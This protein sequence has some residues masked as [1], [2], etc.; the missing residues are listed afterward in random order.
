LYF[1]RIGTDCR[2]LSQIC[3]SAFTASIKA[4]CVLSFLDSV[5]SIRSSNGAFGNDVLHHNRFG[6]LSLPPQTGIGLLIKLQRPRQPKPDDA[7]AA[8]LKVEPMTGGG[9]VYQRHG[10][11]AAFHRLMLSALS[12]FGERNMELLQPFGNAGRSCLNQYATKAVFH[13]R[14]R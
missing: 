6:L 8:A 10:Q 12:S 9:R 11:F 1:S 3:S 13:Q 14:L 4:A 7:G 5:F 2:I